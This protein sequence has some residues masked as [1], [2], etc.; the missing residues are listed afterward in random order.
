MPGFYDSFVGGQR[1]ALARQASE[2]S[3]AQNALQGQQEQQG[4]D[5]K[6][7]LAE[8]QWALQSP[9]PVA[10]V[11]SLPH[12]AAAWQKHGIDVATLDPEHAK[13]L[14]QEGQRRAASQLGIGPPQET[15]GAAQTVGIPGANGA[16]PTNALA[17]I[18]S[19][20]TVRQ[21]QGALPYDPEKFGTPQDLNFNGKPAVAQI[22]T[23]G[24]VRPI[25]GATP[26]NKPAT[27]TPVAPPIPDE[28]LDLAVTTVMADP[29]QMRQYASFGQ[30]G[31]SKRDQINQGIAAKLKAAGMTPGDLVRARASAKGE[32]TSINK[33]TVQQNALDTFEGLAKA[34]GQR[35][36]DLIEQVDSTGIPLI[37]RRKRLADRALGDPNAAELLSV[38]RTFQTEASRIISNPDLKGV[39]SDSA[40]H[41]IQDIAPDGMSADQARRV[42]NR[43]FT[44]FD[45]RRSLIAQT[46]QK[47]SGNLVPGERPPASATAQP[48]ASA[49]PVTATGPKGQKLTL[50]NGQWVPAQ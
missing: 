29:N 12:I 23:R 34:N 4:I 8:T 10:A 45:I 17:Q 5:A 32:L 25:P 50:Q 28:T 22:G 19:G 42:I 9:D 3:I 20:G 14:L 27:Q 13:A 33:M 24:T 1:N 16:A 43:L 38:L 46:L 49:A 37:E 26:Y 7:T 44:E 11:K 40:R 18:G 30:A 48:P 6:Q 21:I 35:A 47:A 2:Q 36:L 15:F 41:E 31:Q 39:V